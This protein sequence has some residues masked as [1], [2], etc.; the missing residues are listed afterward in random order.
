MTC[1]PS[2]RSRCSP[3]RWGCP[4]GPIHARRAL[5]PSRARHPGRR[6]RRSASGPAY[7]GPRGGRPASLAWI[8]SSTLAS[9]SHGQAR[10]RLTSPGCTEL[11]L[12]ACWSQCP[13]GWRPQADP[14][15]LE[16]ACVEGPPGRA[17]L[18]A[19]RRPQACRVGASS[20]PL[21]GDFPDA[22]SGLDPACWVRVPAGMAWLFRPPGGQCPDR[23]GQ[24]WRVSQRPRSVRRAPAH[25]GRSHTRG[26]GQACR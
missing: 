3:G 21:A 6:A 15:G 19:R 16:L 22:P 24:S 8:R 12:P 18:A 5:P 25:A 7:Q 23:P 1:W 17:R 11:G 13:A 4:A 10:S 2:A 9:F 26:I 14:G 20:C